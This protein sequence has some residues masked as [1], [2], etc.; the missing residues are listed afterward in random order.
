MSC[1]HARSRRVEP[2]YRRDTYD[3]RDMTTQHDI[4]LLRLA[5]QRIAG[6]GFATATDAVGWLTAVQAQDY[7]GAVISIALRTES[8]RATTSRRR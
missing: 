3:A 5:A 4:A 8:K 6:T 2:P 7:S 1:C